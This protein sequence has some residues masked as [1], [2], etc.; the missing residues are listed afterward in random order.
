MIQANLENI[1]IRSKYI[2]PEQLE[3]GKKH[4]SQTGLP[5]PETLV[6]LGFLTEEQ[7]AVSKSKYLNIPYASKENKVLKAEVNQ[8]LEKLVPE[9]FARTHLVLPLFVDGRR[10]AIAMADPTDVVL[11]DNIKT[12][13]GGMENSPFISTKAQILKAIDDFYQ[14]GRMLERA[15]DQQGGDRRPAEVE[16]ADVR[17]LDLD[18]VPSQEKGAQSVNLVNAILKQA[19]AERASD[20][21]L[22]CFEDEVA[23]R[24]RIDGALCE[25]TPPSRAMFP[26][27]VARIKVVSNL[28]ISERRL[29]QDGALSLKAQNRFIDVRVS[30]LPTVYGEKVVMRILDKGAMQLNIDHL[31]LEPRQKEDMLKAAEYPNGLFFVTGPTGSGKTTTLYTVIQTVKDVEKNFMTIEDPVEFKL[32]GINQVQVKSSIGLT[33]ASALRSFLRQDP[34]VILVGEVR[35]P[36]TAETCLRAALTGH[37]VL[38]TL[39]TNDA[40]GVVQRLTDMGVERYLLAGTLNL[41]EGQRLVRQLCKFC[42]KPFKPSR[43]LL[44][45]AQ[46]EAQLTQPLDPDKTIFFTAMRCAKC[47]QTGYSGR[48]GIYEVY[49][50]ND[51]LRQAISQNASTRDLNVIAA[52]YGMWNLRASG[53]RKVIEGLTTAEEVRSATLA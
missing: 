10:L 32:L 26:A 2:T 46:R 39:H 6:K 42:K 25:R 45:E 36:E 48:K 19:L 13:T 15:L 21:H 4:Q 37:M 22:E 30:T 49:L 3:N 18:Q 35:D 1:L 11:L 41:V 38:S 31:G 24:F 28:D 34:D 8:N 7:L 51:E 44:E 16:A 12:L 43:E 47:S 33:F 50:L 23:L 29:P 14:Q 17:R 5:L 9:Q 53:W 27:V 52:R 20:I 40:F